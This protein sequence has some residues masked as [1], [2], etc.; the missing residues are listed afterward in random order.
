MPILTIENISLH[1]QCLGE[2]EDLVLIHG[3]G[4]N[5]A[6][7]YL[8]I[9]SVLAQRYRVTVYDLRG[10]GDSS[11]PTTG[12]TLSHLA[13][14]LYALLNHLHIQ[15]AHVVGHS[16]G[17][18]IALHYAALHPEQVA[19][20]TLADTQISCLQPRMRLGDWA[21]WF[22]WKQK[23][24]QQGFSLPSD[25]ELIGM[26]LLLQLSQRSQ[27][28]AQETQAARKPSLKRRNMGLK[29]AERWEKLL[30]TTQAEQ[31][32][33]DLGQITEAYIKQLAMPTLA[34]YGEYSHCLP[35]CWKLKEL[36]QD[37][38]VKIAPQVGHFHP[39]IDPKG[40]LDALQ[41]FLATHP[42][43]T[44]TELFTIKFLVI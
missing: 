5:L 8:G 18:A 23:L 15:R 28:T 40:F 31:E 4:A 1:Y 10:H 44:C 21:Y 35:C 9:A 30:T 20:L 39:V 13:Q 14:D 43:S 22:I 26:R 34:M 12:Y 41:Q 19:T 17:G 16:F 3:L 38:E 25:D 7:W 37:C 33:N 2:G 36:I 29:G 32:L 42:L 6:F 27:A 24:V 11:I